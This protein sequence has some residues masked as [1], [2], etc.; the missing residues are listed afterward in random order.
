MI[1]TGFR[2]DEPQLDVLIRSH[3]YG[4]AVKEERGAS[5]PHQRH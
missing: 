4:G 3:N 5:N 1:E 2:F